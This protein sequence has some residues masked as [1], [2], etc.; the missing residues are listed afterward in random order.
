MDLDP[1]GPQSDADNNNDFFAFVS[2]YWSPPSLRPS[3]R[4]S[5]KPTHSQPASEW[6]GPEEGAAA[7]MSAAGCILVHRSQTVPF[8]R[9]S[10]RL[11]SGG[12]GGGCGRSCSTKC[13][14]IGSNLRD[15]S[16]AE[17]FDRALE[18]PSEESPTAR[19]PTVV[20]L[21]GHCVDASPEGRSSLVSR[22]PGPGR[23]YDHDEEHQSRQTVG[24]TADARATASL[25]RWLRVRAL[26]SAARLLG[27]IL[28][29]TINSHVFHFNTELAPTLVQCPP[30]PMPRARG[31][32]SP[33]GLLIGRRCCCNN[34]NRLLEAEKRISKL[35]L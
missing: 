14:R 35:F 31:K 8:E 11:C 13:V 10:C 28:T 33:G 1:N 25:G 32:R 4:L 2:S 9:R 23:D 22:D 34:D 21:G 27:K 12:G 3:S 18:K 29:S 5:N 6:S 30:N 16:P 19:P 17:R 24:V 26:D 7:V 20:A 15:A